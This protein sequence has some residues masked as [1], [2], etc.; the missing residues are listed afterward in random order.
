M[1]ESTAA[2]AANSMIAPPAGPL[3]APPNESGESFAGAFGADGR[4]GALGGALL[5]GGGTLPPGATGT[6]LFGT[7]VTPCAGTNAVPADSVSDCGRIA[8]CEKS[9]LAA[10]ALR[11]DATRLRCEAAACARLA[12]LC[13]FGW[14]GT[15]VTTATG[16]GAATGALAA[17]AATVAAGGVVVVAGA[18]WSGCTVTVISVVTLA[19][20]VELVPAVVVEGAAAG[21][22]ADGATVA[23]ATGSAA[24][25]AVGAVPVPS[26]DPVGVAGLVDVVAL[27]VVLVGSDAGGLA[28]AVDGSGV[29]PVPVVVLVPA[30]GSVPAGE[31]LPSAGAVAVAEL[32]AVA[33][34]LSAVAA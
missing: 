9:G 17:G 26:V 21:G 2:S 18:G 15:G 33:A 5:R 23:G 32:P 8:G 30:L 4:A 28:A 34:E 10:D 3:S 7:S 14:V 1:I 19:A 27:L 11:M 16:A 13:G 29:V 22:G 25:A 24:F 12:S 6:S 31:A 20:P